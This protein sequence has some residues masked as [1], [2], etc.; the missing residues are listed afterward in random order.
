V[1]S[2]VGTSTLNAAGNY[3]TSYTLY[4]GLLRPR[5]TQSPSPSGGRLLTDV[6]YDTVGRQVREHGSY[7]ATGAPG[8]TLSTATDRQD[9]PNQTRL[10]YDGAGRVTASIFQPY[11]TERWRTTTAYG[12]D[13][14]DTTPPSGGTV[15]STVTDAL[16][17][18]TALREPTTTHLGAD[19]R[20]H[21][22]DGARPRPQ[23]H[24]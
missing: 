21:P 15:S 9:V 1:T 19:H 6:F 5:Q 13:R 17:R 10:V 14:V 20:G 8:T 22:V 16:G 18:T 3:L 4:D 2:A 7:Y 24:G 11:T 23:P 12:G